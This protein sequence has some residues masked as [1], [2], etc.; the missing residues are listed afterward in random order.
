[1]KTFCRRLGDNRGE[2]LLESMA[3]ILIFTFASILLLTMLTTAKE[4][5]QAASQW[6]A[7]KAADMELAEMA[8][9]EA[10]PGTVQF[11]I[12]GCT[13]TVEVEVFG[14]EPGGYYPVREETAP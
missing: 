5:N 6:D 4:I 12:H 11:V 10:A 8:E 7:A 9:Q 14:S 3:A 2:T 1:M 13:E